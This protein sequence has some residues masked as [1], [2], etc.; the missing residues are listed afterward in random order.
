MSLDVRMGL[1]VMV[2]L[3]LAASTLYDLK[4]YADEDGNED[5]DE[6][7][8]EYE[9]DLAE[10]LG[11]TAGTLGPILVAGF[12]AY[13][14][15]LPYMRKLGVKPAVKY[16]SVVLF[17]ALSSIALGLMALAHGYMLRMY[18]GPVEYALAAVIVVVLVT[19]ALLLWGSGR[20]VK[21]FARMI[22]AQRLLS[23]ILIV[24][25]GLHV[26]LMD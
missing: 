16:K 4:A 19:G 13:K 26:A 12:V 21:L 3:L 6:Y 18:A 2:L 10:T 22:H 24:L 7:E 17:H 15:A 8:D 23:I 14:H 1:L 25:L 5:E 9:N 20:R 11:S